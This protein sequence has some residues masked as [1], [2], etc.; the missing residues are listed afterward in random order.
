MGEVAR[1]RD[2]LPERLDLLLLAY[3][4]VTAL[5]AWTTPP[6]VWMQLCSRAARFT[7][8]ASSKRRTNARDLGRLL[9]GRVSPDAP[10]RIAD[11]LSAHRHHARLQVLRSRAMPAWRPRTALRGRQHLDAALAAG[12]GAVLWVA[13]FVYASLIGKMA[14]H[15]AGYD[16][17]HLSGP[18][19]GF[20][21]SEFG[22]RFLNP[23]WIGVE[24]RFLSQRIDM[25]DAGAL[26]QLMRRTR[27]NRIASIAMGWQGLKQYT[28][29]LCAS[30]ATF[31]NGAPAL[32]QRSGAPLLPV[33]TL[34][35]ADG[36]F[37][38]TIEAAAA[39]P[40]GLDRE[41]AERRMVECAAQS[42]EAR[43]WRDPDQFIG[44]TMIDRS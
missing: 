8:L 34:R 12:S 31:A 14:L 15:D 33:F 5:I 3:L 6:A 18:R 19:H 28:V 24:S 43:V 39:I 41:A 17:A 9:A 4:P 32:A 16:V 35:E 20:S 1:P 40:V 29:P 21:P 7:G 11:Q 22:A 10:A 36:S 38:V 37:A 25:R 2:L 42:L 26:V 30:R 27:A 23:L 13:P 44:L